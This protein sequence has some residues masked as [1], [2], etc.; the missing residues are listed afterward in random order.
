MELTFGVVHNC[1][2]LTGGNIGLSDALHECRLGLEGST[3]MLLGIKDTN[4]QIQLSSDYS[5]GF[6]QVRIIRNQHGYVKCLL[7]CLMEQMSCYIYVRTFLFGLIYP[8]LFCWI[9][10]RQDHAA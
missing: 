9:A 6:D 8:D 10:A 7:I 2:E 5:Y 1:W 3:V 4:G